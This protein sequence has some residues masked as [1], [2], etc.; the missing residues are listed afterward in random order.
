[1]PRGTLGCFVLEVHW[2]TFEA[3]VV[4]WRLGGLEIKTLEMYKC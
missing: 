3:S 2:S 4:A 1:M